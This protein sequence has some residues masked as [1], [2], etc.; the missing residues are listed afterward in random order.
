MH[1]LYS[2]CSYLV[3]N[4]LLL[5]QVLTNLRD[6]KAPQKFTDNLPIEVGIT[7][8][9]PD[10]NLHLVI[11]FSLKA[12]LIRTLLEREPSKRPTAEYVHDSDPMKR[13]RKKLK[14]SQACI[15]V[16]WL[17]WHVNYV[18]AIYLESFIA[19]TC[20]AYFFCMPIGIGHSPGSLWAKTF[21]SLAVWP[22]ALLHCRKLGWWLR[23]QS[24]T[25]AKIYIPG[26]HSACV[27]L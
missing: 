22:L 14:K 4:V 17:W 9:L 6:Q 24:C 11:Y 1:T 25:K 8:L 12:E 19:T 7:H 27:E 21:L 16:L 15:P 2:V 5:L 18:V 20:N 23:E 3:I 10:N 26:I 13:L